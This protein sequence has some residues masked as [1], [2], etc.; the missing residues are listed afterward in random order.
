MCYSRG[1]ADAAKALLVDD[2][3][4]VRRLLGTILLKNG[5]EVITMA[6]SLIM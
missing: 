1:M 3:Q 2:Q 6:F 4:V 5:Y